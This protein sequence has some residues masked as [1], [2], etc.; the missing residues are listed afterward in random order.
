MK[1]QEIFAVITPEQEFDIRSVKNKK[2]G[3]SKTE[4]RGNLY[5]A[6]YTELQFLQDKDVLGITTEDGHLSIY[7]EEIEALE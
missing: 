3:K 1:L 5:N 7:I 6:A 4:F 2:L